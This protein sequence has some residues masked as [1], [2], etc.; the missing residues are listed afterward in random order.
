MADKIDEI[1]ELGVMTDE[2]K[3]EQRRSFAYGNLKLSNDAT[4]KESVD[5]AADVLARREERAMSEE[6]KV[7]NAVIQQADMH[8]R[9]GTV[10]V[11]LHLDYGS[12]N[13]I[14]RLSADPKTI[15][16]LMVV[17]GVDCWSKMPDRPIRA[18]AS[19]EKA[20]ALGH[21][22]ADEWLEIS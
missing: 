4:T 13:Q 17:A 22:L 3:E 1:L 16:R 11:E 8:V 15:A 10:E 19:W 20:A 6:F 12:S 21:F 7:L 2:E 9:M 18:R 14:V 5:R